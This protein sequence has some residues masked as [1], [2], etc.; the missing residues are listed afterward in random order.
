LAG[1]KQ[2]LVIPGADFLT[3]YSKF[4]GLNGYNDLYKVE[5]YLSRLNYNYADKY[6]L[7]ASYRRDG[8]SVFHP[9]NRWGNFYGIGG[10]WLISNMIVKVSDDEQSND[11]IFWSL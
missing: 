3:N 1:A 6:F 2:Q 8:S 4:S 7:N 10:A 5:G 9:D 11:N